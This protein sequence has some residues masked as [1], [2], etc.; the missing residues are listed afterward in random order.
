[1]TP[2]TVELVGNVFSAILA[3]VVKSKHVPERATSVRATLR[4]ARK[5]QSHPTGDAGSRR[6]RRTTK[7][8]R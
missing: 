4:T 8:R 6:L 1:L 2:S 7:N 3:D 5:P